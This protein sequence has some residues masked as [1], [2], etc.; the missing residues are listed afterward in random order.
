[1]TVETETVVT[2][3]S[4]SVAGS[5]QG[6]IRSNRNA[7]SSVRKKKKRPIQT[8]HTS[9]ADIF[10][11]KVAS[12]VGD[13]DSSDSDETFVYDS[14]PRDYHTSSSSSRAK[15]D[16]R[17][18][19]L[20]ANMYG[21]A[22]PSH[23]IPPGSPRFSSNRG[24]ASAIGHYGPDEDDEC[25]DE[26]ASLLTRGR[27]RPQQQNDVGSFGLRRPVLVICMVAIALIVGFSLGVMFVAS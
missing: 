26:A 17:L 24:A 1:M 10:A 16:L 27:R 14:N 12:A 3:P 11:A 13:H 25:D 6:S 7:K 21:T 22:K 19:G 2:M 5:A 9:R 8:Q 4:V 18:N 20:S 15:P 23:L